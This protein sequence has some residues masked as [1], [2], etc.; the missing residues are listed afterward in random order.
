MKKLLLLL[1]I[2]GITRITLINYLGTRVIVESGSH[3]SRLLMYKCGYELI[4]GKHLPN[5]PWVKVDK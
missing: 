5:P 2:V 3:L 1:L 4:R